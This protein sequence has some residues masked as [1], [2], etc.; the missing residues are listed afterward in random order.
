MEHLTVKRLARRTDTAPETIR[1]Y[2][3]LGL[4]EEPPRGDNGYRQ[5]PP[6]AAERVR[7]IKHLQRF[8][9]RL[10]AIKQL[11]QVRDEGGCPCG[12]AHRMLQD[13]VE[14]ID[15]ELES[16]AALREEIS[17]LLTRLPDPTAED[18]SQCPPD[19]HVPYT[20]HAQSPVRQ[21]S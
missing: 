21:G 4:L 14:S 1:Y 20:P 18:P 5:Y 13:R 17:G 8:G 11:L 15:A 6:E 19:L 3:K 2:T 16:L 10:D 12:S 9:L 7:F